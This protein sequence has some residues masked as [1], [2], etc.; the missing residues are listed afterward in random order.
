MIAQLAKVAKPAEAVTGLSLQAS[1]PLPDAT[2]RVTW[3]FESVTVLPLA[4]RTV[5]TGW[6][7]KATPLT[8]PAGWVVTASLA[9]APG[10]NVSES[11]VALVR[12][13]LVAVSV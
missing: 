2:A 12:L 5:T 9:A 13:P 1:A 11:V 7:V 4:S 3:A 6:V 8:A 10:A